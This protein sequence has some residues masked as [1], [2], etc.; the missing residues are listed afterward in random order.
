MDCSLKPYF[1]PILSKFYIIIVLIFSGHKVTEYY[2]YSHWFLRSY[3]DDILLAPLVLPVVLVLLR[4]IFSKPQLLLDKFMVFGFV[5][6][7]FIV[8]E[9]VLPSYSGLYVRDYWDFV[10]YFWGATIFYFYQKSKYIH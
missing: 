7:T 6:I 9:L 5:A 4:L 3:L 2:N 1:K 10:F 8:F